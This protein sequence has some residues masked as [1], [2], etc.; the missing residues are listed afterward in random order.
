MILIENVQKTYGHAGSEIVALRSVNLRLEA[1]EFVA[2]YGASGSGK[3]TLLNLLCGVDAPS[4]GRILIDGKDLATMSDNE[5]T[6]FRRQTVGFVFQ[7]FNLLPTLNVLENVMLPGQLNGLG[8]REAEKRGRAL[9]A[10]LGLAERWQS[11]PDAISGGQQQRVALCRALINDPPL[12]LADE[13]TGNLDS[14]NGLYILSLLKDCSRTKS[15]TILMATH[16]QEA[17]RFAD[18]ILHMRDGELFE[19]PRP[20]APSVETLEVTG[21]RD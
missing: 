8:H 14:E 21:K 5:A 3:S 13:P 15:K 4:A 6:L 16:S 7:F 10:Q 19:M 12:I 17:A 20:S 9:L 18:R 2:L 11:M 1:G